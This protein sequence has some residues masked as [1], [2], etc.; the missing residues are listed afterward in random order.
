MRT[1]VFLGPCFKLNRR[2]SEN[3]EAFSPQSRSGKFLRSSVERGLIDSDKIVKI[4]YRNVIERLFY[5]SSGKEVV[6]SVSELV[7]DVKQLRVWDY[8]DIVICLGSAVSEAVNRVMQ[9]EKCDQI[10][11]HVSVFHLKHPSFVIRQ[12]VEIRDQYG[13]DIASILSNI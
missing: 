4:E 1:I 13:A 7:G 11:K 6:P 8:A 10:A 5:N 9:D 12:P 3:F 2:T